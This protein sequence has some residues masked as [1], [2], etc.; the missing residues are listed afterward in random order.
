MGDLGVHHGGD[1][2]HGVPTWLQITDAITASERRASWR[3]R[4]TPT[5]VA[6]T[7][8][9]GRS[10]LAWARELLDHLEPGLV[11]TVTPATW[12]IEDV[13]EWTEQLGGVDALALTDVFETTSPASVLE[14]GIPVGLLDD[15]PATPAVWADVLLPVS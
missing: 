1:L 13:R 8:P 10:D 5:I 15:Q 6:V 7:L 4:D 9:R 2:G 14:L 11:W 3:R 12:K